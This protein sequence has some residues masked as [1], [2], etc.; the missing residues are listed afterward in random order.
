MLAES[1]RAQDLPR[2]R[3][4]RGAPDPDAV[5]K[6]MQQL[7]LSER[8]LIMLGGSACDQEAGQAL[9]RFAERNN[10]PVVTSLR[11]QDYYENFRPSYAGDLGIAANPNVLRRVQEADMLLVIGA[12]MG[13]MTTQGYRTPKAPRSLQ[14]FA[15]VCPSGDELGRVY[16]ADAPVV[17]DTKLFAAAIAGRELRN[18]TSR[19]RWFESARADYERMLVADP[20]PGA[21]AVGA[22]IAALRERLPEDAVMTNGA[23]NYA[24]WVHKFWQFR[25]YRSQLAPTSGAMG[26]G[27][28]EAVAAK[29]VFP[30]RKVVGFAG[31]GCF[32]MNGQELATIR[33]YGLDPLIIVVNNGMYGTIRMHQEREY[34]GHVYGT[35]LENP[36]FAALAASY[37]LHSQVLD[38]TE[39]VADVFDRALSAG[40]PALVECRID[41]EGIAPR[42]TISKLRQ[43]ARGRGG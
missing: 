34:P 6:V 7:E 18:A 3:I 40:G 30:D 2:A 25:H 14:F 16:Y 12:R 23:G 22:V 36:D 10:V 26:Y 8:P 24:A 32:L 13:E 19:K 29:L 1:A 31:D 35:A 42:M 4:A 33:Q 11:C 21:L 38:R 17:S 27:V 28:P 39:D 20:Q 43:S 15:H 37:G 9:G 5:D 41:S